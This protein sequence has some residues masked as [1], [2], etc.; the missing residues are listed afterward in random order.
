[1]R[2][3][4]VFGDSVAKGV[5]YDALRQKYIFLKDSCA[6]LFKRS[7]DSDVKNYSRFGCTV[8]K[9]EEMLARH[10]SEIAGYDSICLEFGGNDCDFKWA[11]IAA[12]PDAEHL[13]NVPLAEFEERYRAMVG[14]IR[15][16]GGKPVMLTL[17]PLLATRFFDWISR[18]LDRDNILKWLGDVEHIYRWHEMYNDVVCDIARSEN[19]PLINIR[20][21]FLRQNRYGDFLCEDGMHPNERGHVLISKTLQA[22]MQN[23]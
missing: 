10:E 8:I 17:P 22:Y 3:F 14:R 15:S 18:G 6:E 4:C 13:P 20:R 9:G 11:E 5:V 1:M 2:T 21:S 19:V 16:L 12:A 7:T 23:A